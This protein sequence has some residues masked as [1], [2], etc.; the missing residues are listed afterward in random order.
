VASA[1]DL[2]GDAGRRE[3]SGT[4][5]DGVEDQGRRA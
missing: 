5:P 1:G 4:R 3:R 2:A